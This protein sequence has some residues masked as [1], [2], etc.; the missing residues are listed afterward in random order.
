MNGEMKRRIRSDKTPVLWAQVAQF[1]FLEDTIRK[2]WTVLLASNKYLL[3][4]VDSALHNRSEIRRG[5]SGIFM[6]EL[7]KFIL[8][9]AES[10]KK[11]QKPSAEMENHLLSSLVFHHSI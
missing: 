10:K 3:R 5:R 9:I 11:V 8:C 2:Y 6:N 7:G 4:T 1:Y